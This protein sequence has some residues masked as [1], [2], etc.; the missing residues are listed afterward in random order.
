MLGLDFSPEAGSGGT[1]TPG[2]SVENAPSS[3]SV[4]SA[5]YYSDKV[6][7]FQKMLY[8]LQGAQ[9]AVIGLVDYGPD[10]IKPELTQLL[11]ELDL[12]IGRY[13]LVAETLNAG[14]AWINSKGAE[15]TKINVP[16]GLGIAPALIATGIGATVAVAA[17]LIAWG[18]GWIQAVI[19]VVK[20]SQLLGNM[21]KEQRE[22]LAPELLALD[23]ANRATQTSPLANIAVIVKWA[24]VA[25]A[26]YFAFQAYQKSR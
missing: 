20:R 24:A 17:G 23:E 1:P 2:M 12:K 5:K 6:A 16:A 13:K 10:E 7:E 18:S 22:R 9:E 11:D 19:D 4:F 26:A 3:T 8:A 15:F 14:I 25:A 21:T